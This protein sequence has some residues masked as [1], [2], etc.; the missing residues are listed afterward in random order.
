MA[1][2]FGTLSPEYALEQQRLNRQQKMA[3]MLLAQGAQP[4]AAGQM[5]SGRYVA[6]AFTQ[7]LQAALNPVIGAYMSK[8]ADEEALKLAD[9][10]RKEQ[11]NG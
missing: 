4:Q 10:L 11:V 3:E 1:D 7:Q 2:L 6:P 9:R 8:S 5:V